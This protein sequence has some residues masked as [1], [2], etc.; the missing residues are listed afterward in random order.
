MISEMGLRPTGKI[1]YPVQ[2]WKHITLVFRQCEEQKDQD[3]CSVTEEAECTAEV[4]E[5]GGG[6]GARQKPRRVLR[7]EHFKRNENRVAG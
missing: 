3:S 4:I 1:E 6:G 5:A 2:M 7:Q